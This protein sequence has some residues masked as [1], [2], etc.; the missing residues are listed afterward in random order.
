MAGLDELD[1]EI[2]GS[3]LDA[4]DQEIM[5]TKAAPA[6]PMAPGLSDGPAAPVEAPPG[7]DG[8]GTTPAGSSM[9]KVGQD[10]LS[11]VYTQ[12]AR[13]LGLP[14]DAILD[15]AQL[16]GV[17]GLPEPGRATEALLQ[18]FK[19]IGLTNYTGRAETWAHTIG[20]EGVRQL[21]GYFAIRGVAPKVAAITP[22]NAPQT[23]AVKTAQDVMAKPGTTLAATVASAPGVAVGG[24]YGERWGGG[25]GETIGGETGRKIGA[26]V[27]RFGGEMI[28]GVASS[29]PVLGFKRGFESKR[30]GMEL[31]EPEY[32]TPIRDLAAD[33]EAPRTFAA[34]QVDRAMKTIDRRVEQIFERFQRGMSPKDDPQT[35][36]ARLN[37]NIKTY[38]EK[39]VKPFE[40]AVWD[41]VYSHPKTGANLR[42]ATVDVSDII[43]HMREDMIQSA[44]TGRTVPTDVYNKFIKEVADYAVDGSFIGYREMSLKKL[45]EWRT[46]IREAATEAGASTAQ[47][48][49]AQGG[50]QFRL[51]NLQDMILQRLD[52]GVLR[53]GGDPAL[54]GQA[55]AI[56]KRAN[57]LFERGPLG[58]LRAK[59]YQGQLRVDPEKTGSNLMKSRKGLQAVQEG[60]EPLADPN[61]VSPAI[62][63]LT[64]TQ[65]AVSTAAKGTI[66]D[67]AKQALKQ[68]YMAKVHG[69]YDAAKITGD[70]GKQL[71]AAASASQA[72]MKSV[73]KVAESYADAVH[74][75]NQATKRLYTYNQTRR[76][77]E[78]S[79]LAQ[80]AGKDTVNAVRALYN[81]PDPVA[82]VRALKKQFRGDPDALA[83]LRS[84]VA[85]EFLVSNQKQSAAAFN[86][87]LDSPKH[88][89]FM[90]E[91]LGDEAF[92]RLQKVAKTAL[93]I[94]QN[95]GL[96]AKKLAGA[97]LTPMAHI[98]GIWGGNKFADGV[99]TTS[100]GK[101]S[102]P[103]KGAKWAK[104][105]VEKAFSNGNPIELLRSAIV[106]PHAER[107]LNMRTPTNL[108]E[109][110]QSVRRLKWLGA[111]SN[112]AS[113][114][115]LN[116]Y[117]AREFK[118]DPNGPLEITIRPPRGAQ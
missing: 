63:D 103:A 32:K 71:G 40:D 52:E 115:I 68:D 47:G 8:A 15:A 107:A 59:D 93:A 18:G 26:Q 72:H 28:G 33:P 19:K 62:R 77:W 25:I 92:E 88:A 9:P 99:A 16:V 30:P 116:A 65:N 98:I 12:S 118:K 73:E 24:E 80:Y 48:R 2:M 114:R 111:A 66:D 117:E 79:A 51:G 21:V 20:E 13:I 50:V 83:G 108:S 7:L 55:Q 44:N 4:L 35:A 17:K 110:H 3:G 34:A 91:A 86:R 94:E 96:S 100:Y 113:D 61:A 70:P 43:A 39:S 74:E 64:R 37:F 46:A 78:N 10:L 106:D 5:G 1:A 31:S 89:R 69:D 112:S 105:A 58:E 101:L 95:R 90:R 11:G 97:L 38:Y 23:L 54:L 75:M 53:A 104:V 41:R 82:A 60:T 76:D 84:A 67:S 109:I 102:Y 57:D 85:E 29:S 87:Q 22:T 6:A 27:G 14:V 42:N 49:A 36:W 81:A 45:Q 56:S